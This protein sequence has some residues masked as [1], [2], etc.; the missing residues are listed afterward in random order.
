MR[1]AFILPLP[2]SESGTE[3][4]EWVD[5]GS[6]FQKW[7]KKIELFSEGK[8]TWDVFFGANPVPCQFLTQLVTHQDQNNLLHLAVLQNQVVY[9]EK[10]VQICHQLKF[11]RNA[12]GLTPYELA[13]FLPRKEIRVLLGASHHNS[14][15]EQH[16]FCSF[17]INPSSVLKDLEFLKMP[18]FA[19][20]SIFQEILIKV[21]RAKLSDT[22]PSEKILMGIYFDEEIQTGSR[23]KVSVR[24]IDSKIGFGVFAEQRIASCSFVGEY[25]G[26]VKEKKQHEGRHNSYGIRYPVWEINKQKFIIDAEKKGNFTRFMNHSTKPNLGLYS[27]YWRGI[28][29]LILVALKEIAEG[30]QLMFDYGASFWKESEVEPLP[31]SC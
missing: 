23:V 13:A 28:P 18:L 17:K 7:K 6:E 25:T 26:I 24:F 29:R 4:K 2:K 30:E 9:V 15:E 31:L 20:E 16:L 12:Y 5:F 19:N 1:Q 21:N 22:I 3:L 8:L 10:L 11:R 27:V 14:F